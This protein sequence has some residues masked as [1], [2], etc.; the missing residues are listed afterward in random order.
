MLH[1][2]MRIAALATIAS[3]AIALFGPTA[4]G[5]PQ[6]STELPMPSTLMQYLFAP[7]WH[8]SAT[9]TVTASS[10][11]DPSYSGV[12]THRWDIIPWEIYT[13]ATNSMKYYLEN[14]TAT[15]SGHNATK[16]WTV[17]ATSDT[18]PGWLQF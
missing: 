13:N 7:I 18:G 11:T 16:H 5:Q 14:W 1:R 4:F 15:G 10:P 8:G 6:G 9:C 17:N 2:W 12:E 3:C